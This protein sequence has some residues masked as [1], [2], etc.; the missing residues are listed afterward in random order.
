MSKHFKTIQNKIQQYAEFLIVLEKD[1]S[2]LNIVQEDLKSLR[3]ISN[4]EALNKIRELN[5]EYSDLKNEISYMKKELKNLYSELETMILKSIGGN[6][7]ETSVYEDGLS[8]LYGFKV[9]IIYQKAGE[10]PAVGSNPVTI[11]ATDD[12]TLHGK[13]LKTLSY[14]L[15][16]V[17]TGE[18]LVESE[19]EICGRIKNVPIGSE[20]PYSEVVM[21]RMKI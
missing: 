1:K 11:I 15:K 21:K 2:R 3:K 16:N 20:I 17:D 7:L 18:I 12:K 19:V 6:D 10:I 8:L 9:E 13:I 5:R 4:D 14:G